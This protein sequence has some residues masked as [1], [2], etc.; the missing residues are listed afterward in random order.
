MLSSYPALSNFNH[1]RLAEKLS[2]LAQMLHVPAPLLSKA[3]VRQPKVL[4]YSLAA[5]E[6]RVQR[7]RCVMGSQDA[8]T[9]VR[10]LA[11]HLQSM[12]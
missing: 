3:L 11:G 4:G 5:L 8:V 10:R 1:A 9:E 2:G 12:A 6:D 7:L